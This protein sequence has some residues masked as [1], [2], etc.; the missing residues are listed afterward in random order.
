VELKESERYQHYE[1]MFFDATGFAPFP[2]QKRLAEDLLGTKLLKI[3]T[4]AGKTASVV[5]AWVWN[6]CCS[7]QGPSSGTPRRLVYCLPMRV[8]VEQT[9]ENIIKWLDRLGILNGTAS[10]GQRDGE[11]ILEDY[12]PE[13]KTLGSSPRRGVSVYKLMGGEHE[14][15]WDLYP[16]NDQI[17]VGTQ[18]MLLSRALN[19]GYAMSRFRWPIQYGLLNNDCLWVMDE[20]QLMGSGFSTSAQLEALRKIYGTISTSQTIWMSATCEPEWLETV[21]HKPPVSHETLYL[22]EDDYSVET[23][24]KRYNAAKPLEK[25][26][27]F[28]DKK[29]KREIMDYAE[30][31]SEATL[32]HHQKQGITLVIVNTVDRVQNVYRALKKKISAEGNSPDIILI[33]SRFRLVERVKL[34]RL[35]AETPGSPGFP[36]NGRIIVSTQVV[37][38]GVDI[39]SSTMVTELA[40]WASMVQRFGRL[41]RYGECTEPRAVWVDIGWKNDESLALPYTAEELEEARDTLDQLES[42]SLKT[43]DE[44]G[45]K[46]G[47]QHKYVLRRK[48][49]L[50]LFDTTPDL[51]GNDVDVSRFIRDS[52]DTNVQV[53]WRRWGESGET[54]GRPPRELPRASR[55]EL[56]SAPVGSF[57][58]F[59]KKHAVWIWDHIREQ[60]SR[61]AA[62]QVFPGQVFLIHCDSGG[63]DEELGWSMGSTRPVEPVSIEE[64]LLNESIGDDPYTAQGNWVTLNKHS[65]DAVNEMNALVHSIGLPELIGFKDVLT[66]VVHHH[67]LGKAHPVFQEA[68]LN[69]LTDEVEREARQA[70]V[71]GKAGGVGRFRYGRRFF[72][73]ELVSALM[74]LANRELVRVGS[75]LM[76]DLVAYLA[77]SHHGKV[78][79]SIRSLSGE[80]LPWVRDPRISKGARFARGVWE[81]DTVPSV[82]LSGGRVVPETCLTLDVMELGLTESGGP[83]WIEMATRLR[84]MSSVGPFRLGYLEAVTRVA[85]WRASFKEAQGGEE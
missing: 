19:R 15:D 45:S 28:L 49:L 3:P 31:L 77:A 66:E 84:D 13:P 16:E 38:A 25:A 20:V 83:S 59:Q 14:K 27:V 82:E 76:K 64:A 67:D 78:R 26:G 80:D 12:D 54:P 39:S 55:D 60:W 43:I 53:Y 17:I 48:D 70:Q 56:C 2:Y 24:R 69:T 75:E 36:E 71:W 50:E 35:L 7:P 40:P 73:H 5:L 41:N 79:V 4:G 22:G 1:E 44:C 34:N 85:D 21:D 32:T 81:G 8:L 33:H 46:L 51:S 61:P 52:R 68:A 18:D 57:N 62:G 58:E 6:R 63:Y 72:R 23:L 37:E 9:Y 47:Y 11:R 10:W 74:I 42:V 65:A 30:A 29:G